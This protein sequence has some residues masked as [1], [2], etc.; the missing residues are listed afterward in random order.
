MRLETSCQAG[1]QTT[2]PTHK[3]AVSKVENVRFCFR[4]GDKSSLWS[5]LDAFELSKDS[6]I[7]S[8]V[9]PLLPVDDDEDDDDAVVTR[10]FV[11]TNFASRVLPKTVSVVCI[12]VIFFETARQE[13][14]Q[15]Q[16]LRLL[17]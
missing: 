2:K 4:T 16:Q 1:T 17:V 13:K 14:Q 15:Q 6:T 10:L 11:V 5:A 12:L 9:N 3:E 8:R 7:S